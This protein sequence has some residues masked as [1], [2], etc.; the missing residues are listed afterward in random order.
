LLDQVRRRIPP[1]RTRPDEVVEA[2]LAEARVE[3]RQAIEQHRGVL[4]EFERT[5]TMIA[6]PVDRR[7]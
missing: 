7:P 3:H 5:E 2:T 1:A 4:A 6:G